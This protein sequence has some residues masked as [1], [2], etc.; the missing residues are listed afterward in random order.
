M[1][2]ADAEACRKRLVARGRKWLVLPESNGTLLY[3]TMA[4]III[5]HPAKQK[6]A[7]KGPASG[8]CNLKTPKSWEKD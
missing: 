3:R 6:C 8:A 4:T 2:N 5:P 1:E 7:K